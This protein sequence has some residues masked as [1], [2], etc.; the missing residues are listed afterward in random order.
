MPALL[1]GNELEMTWNVGDTCI[2]TRRL[3]FQQPECS[4]LLIEC[5]EQGI[6]VAILPDRSVMAVHWLRVNLFGIVGQEEMSG[7][8][9]S[10]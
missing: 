6:V 4:P 2:A 3:I 7:L 1:V 5:G 8:S 9:P 10:E